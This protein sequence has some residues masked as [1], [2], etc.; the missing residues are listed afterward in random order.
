MAVS[1]RALDHQAG[2]AD[3]IYPD[4]VQTIAVSIN[5]VEA[6]QAVPLT[7][8]VEY[9]DDSGV[10]YMVTHN[11]AVEVAR[12]DA[13][14]AAEGRTLINIGEIITHAG[15]GD[16]HSGGASAGGDQVAGGKAGDVVSTRSGVNLGVGEGT[17]RDAD[18]G[19]YGTG[20][21]SPVPSQ[22]CIHCGADLPPGFVFCGRCGKSQGRKCPGCGLDVPVGFSFCGKCGTK[23]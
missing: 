7:L 9:R 21:E 12:Q 3:A 20:A 11:V 10:P 15:G 16:V 23:L 1:G 22:E 5:P 6:G 18:D 14:V 8:S 19:V 4:A 17:A 2:A 13:P